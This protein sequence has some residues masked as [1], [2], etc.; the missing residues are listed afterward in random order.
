MVKCPAVYIS[1]VRTQVRLKWTSRRLGANRLMLNGS[2][3]QIELIRASVTAKLQRLGN[4]DAGLSFM[5]AIS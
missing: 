4:G 2:S 1:T 3:F 5:D